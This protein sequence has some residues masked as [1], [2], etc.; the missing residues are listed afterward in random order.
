[1]RI[2]LA[3]G[4]LLVAGCTVGPDYR[5]PSMPMPGAYGR[6]GSA[7]H[8]TTQTSTTQPVSL[9]LWWNAFDDPTLNALIEQAIKS[10]QDLKIAES[11]VREARALRAV[12][13]AAQWPTA[14]ASGSYSRAR[15]S[16]NISGFAGGFGG[17]TGG[18]TGG[19]GGT[20]GFSF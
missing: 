4:L 7:E 10:N 2:Y 15:R 16:E 8:P 17:T 9:A 3:I 12:A 14:N 13:G 20:T 6:S 5:A 19:T 1:M 18:G 11:R